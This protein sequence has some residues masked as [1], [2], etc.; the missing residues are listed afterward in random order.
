[1]KRALVFVISSLLV[2]CSDNT[3]PNIELVQDM[4]VS[5][6]LKAR[7][8]GANRV[9]PDHT[10]PVGFTPYEFANDPE[11]AKANKNPFAGDMSPE[12]LMVGQK[13]YETQCAV[14]H[15]HWGEGA[16]NSSVAGFMALK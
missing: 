16:Q 2:G 13:H 11:G 5:P 6:A 9:P 10:V 3:K 1:M 4:M 12:V 7:R 8:P 15:G 14:C